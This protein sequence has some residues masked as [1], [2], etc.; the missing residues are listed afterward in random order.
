MTEFLI[1]RETEDEKLAM[2]AT[3]F[4]DVDLVP[5]QNGSGMLAVVSVN[6]GQYVCQ[7][8]G[9]GF[10]PSIPR[11]RGVDTTLYPGSPPVVLHPGCAVP[12]PKVF[13]NKLR[14]LEIRRKMAKVA[15]ASASLVDAALD[16]GK[17]IVGG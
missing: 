15:N 9:K 8:C 2:G 12:N 13:I 11:L 16:A 5:Q 10:N 3:Y 6:K 1:R 4:D 17:R 7:G 14:G